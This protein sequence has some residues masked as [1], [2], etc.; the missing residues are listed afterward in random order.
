[1]NLSFIEK[2]FA[3]FKY[4]ASSFLSISLFILCLLLFL[5][6]IINNK[7][8]NKYANYIVITIY[9]VVFIAIIIASPSYVVYSIDWVIK[10]IMKYIYFPS[11][12]AYFMIN[13]VSVLIIMYSMKSKK[14]YKK[15]RIFNYVIFNI[16]FYLFISFV[17]IVTYKKLD[18]RLL[19]VLYKN[20][21]VLSIVQIS[22][23]LFFIWIIV[24]LFYRLYLFYQKK[25]DKKIES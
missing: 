13:L 19:E 22:N 25:Y 21:T 10:G 18:I 6:L 17:A 8:K 15:K 11:T 23:L 24:T 9:A 7:K 1:M 20:N 14:I 4:I 16:I 12:A 2:I 3:I 5:I